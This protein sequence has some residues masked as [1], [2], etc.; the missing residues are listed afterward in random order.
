MEARE[1]LDIRKKL[2][3]TQED[4]ARMMRSS[5]AGLKRWEEGSAPI[6]RKKEAILEAVM[7]LAER[8]EE[9]CSGMSDGREEIGRLRTVLIQMGAENF[10]FFLAKEKKE[11]LPR[12][13]WRRLAAVIPA[14][15]FMVGAPVGMVGA[16][17]G[18]P[19]VQRLVEMLGCERTK[20][21]ANRSEE[22]E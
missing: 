17:C 11:S 5:L 2:G 1:I 4:L 10:L 13:C 14:I 16:M 3:A 9:A 7:K 22:G 15:G 19:L 6:P 8:L 20:N 18:S 12:S 21:L